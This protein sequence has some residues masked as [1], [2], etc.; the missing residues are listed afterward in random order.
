[1]CEFFSKQKV[2]ATRNSRQLLEWVARGD[3]HIGLAYS[4]S[5]YEGLKGRGLPFE[6]QIADNMKEGCYFTAGVASLGLVNRAPHPNAAKVF[7]NW[8]LTKKTQTAWS[9]A[10]GNWSRRLHL[11]QD[12][13]NPRI[14]PRQE[15]LSSYQM[16]YK[17]KWVIKRREVQSFMRTLIK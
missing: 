10:S 11:T 12:H 9:R 17:E 13:L 15:K 2:K 4:S 7:I 16:N 1:M 14:I 5:I 3:Y 8:L 6:I